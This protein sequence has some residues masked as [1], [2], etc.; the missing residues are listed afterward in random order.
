M[1]KEEF[2]AIAAQ[3]YDAWKQSESSDPKV[4]LH[5]YEQGFDRLIRGIGEGSFQ[6]SLGKTPTDRRKKNDSNEVREG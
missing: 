4:G 5:E 3:Q 6:A 2:L 1:T